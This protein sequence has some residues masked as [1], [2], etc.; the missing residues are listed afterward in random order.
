LFTEFQIEDLK[1]KNRLVMAPMCMYTADDDGVLKDWHF[2]HY[3]TRAIGGVGTII[4]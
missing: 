1:L 2:V 3:L 4:L